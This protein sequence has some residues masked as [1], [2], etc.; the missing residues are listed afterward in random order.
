MEEQ[1]KIERNLMSHE[2][3]KQYIDNNEDSTNLI[4]YDGVHKFKS[5]RRAMKR[6]QVASNGMVVPKRPF[7]NRANTSRRKGKHSRGL[8]EL[9]R[10][11]YE[12]IK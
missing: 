1:K 2:E 12:Q 8:N 5:V 6:S 9:K 3:F 4:T 11:I 7:N 10:E